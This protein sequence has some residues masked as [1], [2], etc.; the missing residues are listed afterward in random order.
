[1]PPEGRL[2]HEKPAR[3]LRAAPASMPAGIS[4]ASIAE[5]DIEALGYSSLRTSCRVLGGVFSAEGREQSPDHAP[6]LENGDI[7]DTSST[8]G[9][10]KAA[11]GAIKARPIDAA[12][13]DTSS[14]EPSSRIVDAIFRVPIGGECPSP[15]TE[16][17]GVAYASTAVRRK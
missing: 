13:D 9:D 5:V 1:M 8:K 7:S 3:R 11:L 12:R 14:V 2:V 6:D 16:S 17:K 4:Q 10:F 15:G